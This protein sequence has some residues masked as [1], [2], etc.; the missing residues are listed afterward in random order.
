MGLLGMIPGGEKMMINSMLP[1]VEKIFTE[2]NSVQLFEAI[3]KAYPP[4]D[5]KNRVI[6]TITKEKDGKIY[7]CILEMNPLFSYVGTL[8]SW[9][10]VD[11]IKFLISNYKN[12]G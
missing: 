10:L 4:K 2:E 8:A 9:P 7:F 1:L 5:E 11:G 6:C 3:T 12:N